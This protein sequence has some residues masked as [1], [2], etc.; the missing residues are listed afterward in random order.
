MSWVCRQIERDLIAKGLVPG[1]RKFGEV[2]FRKCR[3]YGIC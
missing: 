1:S 3:R 2:Y